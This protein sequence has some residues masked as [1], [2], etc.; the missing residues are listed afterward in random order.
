[1]SR[2]LTAIGS[3]KLTAH[4][5]VSLRLDNSYLEQKTGRTNECPTRFL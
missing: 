2:K 4:E 5:L 1:M 3:D